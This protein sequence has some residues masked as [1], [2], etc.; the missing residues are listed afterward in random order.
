MTIESLEETISNLPAAELF[1]IIKVKLGRGTEIETVAAIRNKYTGTIRLDA[2]EAWSPERAVSVLR[3]LERYDIELCEQPSRAGRPQE[4]RWIR[5][6]SRIPIVADEDVKCG[7]DLLRLVD[8]VDGICV[9]L[10]K[11]GGLREALAMIHAARALGFKVMMS[12]MIESQILTTAAAHLSPLADWID[13]D[14]PLLT[15]DDPFDGIRYDAAKIVFPSGPGLGVQMRVDVV[16][17]Q[18][19]AARD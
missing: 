19:D 3:E 1:P 4:L 12:C 5:E 7:A 18:S 11:C 15:A 2:N 8:C 13:L 6:H 17:E 14:A 10:S 16:R 9:K